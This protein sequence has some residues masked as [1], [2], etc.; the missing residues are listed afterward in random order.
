MAL[1]SRRTK[2]VNAFDNTIAAY[3][4]EREADS[5][6]QAMAYGK[7]ADAGCNNGGRC[8]AVIMP[9][10]SDFKCDVEINAARALE[11]NPRMLTHFRKVY[12]ARGT[13]MQA[14]DFSP[15]IG[16]GALDLE[17]REIVGKRFMEVGISPL[18]KYR[19]VIDTR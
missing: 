7:N 3:Q 15:P 5:G 14:E 17:M 2:W 19:K 13:N 12:Q 9:S 16:T 8:S 4:E 11:D 6:L 18:S 1:V 10:Y